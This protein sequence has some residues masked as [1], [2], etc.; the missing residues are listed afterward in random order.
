MHSMSKNDPANDETEL[1][2]ANRMAT[3][4]GFARIMLE[5]LRELAP[6]DAD[7]DVS[8]SIDSEAA[9][10]GE[11]MKRPSY[12]EFAR[13]TRS[14]PARQSLNTDLVRIRE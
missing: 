8:K 2:Q 3:I 4:V 13:L 5:S 10:L 9:T 7:S 11:A 1:D 14:Q 12:S 6:S